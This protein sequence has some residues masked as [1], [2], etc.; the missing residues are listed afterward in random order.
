MVKVHFKGVNRSVNRTST[1]S[2]PPKQL[3]FA[4]SYFLKMYTA[5]CQGLL[6][7]TNIYVIIF[8]FIKLTI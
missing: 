6:N 8:V 4:L 5:V 7:K 1:V 2:R 3:S